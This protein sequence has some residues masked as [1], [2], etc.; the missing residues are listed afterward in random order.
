M[1]AGTAG[2]TTAAPAADPWPGSG[3]LRWSLEGATWPH[4][5]HSRFVDAG[6]LRWHVQR[7]PGPAGARHCVL[8]LHGT[9]AST[10]SWRALAPRLAAHA[11]VIAL[12]LPG[13]GFSGM[14]RAGGFSLPGMAE[15][16]AALL[17]ALAARPTAVV[18]HSAGAAIGA[19]LCLSGLIGP[20]ALIGINGA[21]LPFGGPA[22]RLFSPAARLLAASGAAPW[23]F[24]R[25]ARDPA[26]ARRLLAGTGS[27]IDPLGE[28]AYARLLRSPDHVAAALSMMAH[29]RLDGLLEEL[30]ALRPA[31]LLLAGSADLTVP[32]A[33]S[34]RVARA[35]PGA[36]LERLAGLGHLAHEEQPERIAAPILAFLDL[37]AG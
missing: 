23:L 29:W 25:L 9:G 16:I 18:G 4:A 26:L 15:A 13:H 17:R 14:P 8:L 37:A 7:F 3:P 36:R 32:C 2:T 19:R 10:H 28:R 24:A 34:E 21:W 12:D 30:P 1:P 20:E 27:R 35:L 31:L 33:Q 6:G 22:S 5:E 11:E